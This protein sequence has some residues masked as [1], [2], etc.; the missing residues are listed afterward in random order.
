MEFSRQA[1]Q[2]GRLN[3]QKTE[4]TPES[5]GTIDG[6]AQVR[7]TRELD[8][9]SQRMA[10]QMGARALSMM[11]NPVEQQRTAGWMQRFGMS[12]Q[13]YQFNQAKMMMQA[14]AAQV[15]AA[16]QQQQQGK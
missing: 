10:G 9:G 2:Q 6:T 8:I 15:A 7:P 3:Q 11:N 13:G 16:A 12:N 5:F 14:Q 1:I 4:E